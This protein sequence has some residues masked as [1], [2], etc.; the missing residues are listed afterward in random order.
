ML[1]TELFI[2]D[3]DAEDEFD[4]AAAKL[5]ECLEAE[6]PIA[7]LTLIA[8]QLDQWQVAYYYS[9]NELPERDV[10]RAK[11]EKFLAF[12][13]SIDKQLEQP[14]QINEVD[15]LRDSH[16]KTGGVSE[17]WLIPLTLNIESPMLLSLE[18]RARPSKA[19]ADCAQMCENFFTSLKAGWRLRQMRGFI[20][21]LTDQDQA[22]E[23]NQQDSA[24]QQALKQLRHM[25]AKLLESKKLAEI[26]SLVAGITHDINT[27]LGVGV[28]A[29]SHLQQKIRS[30]IDKY[31]S[32]N[33]TRKDFESYN[34][35]ALNSAEIILTN[36]ER[37][38][39]LVKSFKQVAVDQSSEL[40]RNFDLKLYIEQILRSLGP[41]ITK[42]NH[43]VEVHC[44]EN[45]NLN[46]YPGAFSQI[47]T[48][49][50]MNSLIH[51][52]ENINQGTI[53]ITA[54]YQ[55]DQVEIN[56]RDN[57]K[58]ISAEQKQKIF[59]PYFTTKQSIG[60][61][62]LGTHIIQNLVTQRLGG[63]IRCESELGHGIEFHIT[64]PRPTGPN[65]LD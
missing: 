35:L 39:T 54:S 56:Y 18:L 33:I 12:I 44:P 61:S 53:T 43:K 11:H 25:Q 45:L 29:A 65:T 22:G 30:F 60:G 15:Q 62:G 42:T 14:R 48:N 27:P 9:Q 40:R 1:Q 2:L 4:Q 7:N 49:L 63:T 46:S 16:F 58:G 38:A 37:A 32:G 47:L 23:S 6:F 13:T 51:G 8:K 34:H 3:E 64:I 21:T 31:E 52:F 41:R 20:S 26:G 10:L 5:A 28:T 50:I 17:I 19:I 55:D 24:L 59:E 36:L 57:G